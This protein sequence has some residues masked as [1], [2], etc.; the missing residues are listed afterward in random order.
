MIMI[1][2]VPFKH[3]ANMQVAFKVCGVDAKTLDVGAGEVRYVLGET[4]PDYL[5]DFLRLT[6]EYVSITWSTELVV[7]RT[8]QLLFGEDAWRDTEHIT[9]SSVVV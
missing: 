1:V 3:L 2:R 4:E 6:A 9:P 8:Y 7:V 5:R